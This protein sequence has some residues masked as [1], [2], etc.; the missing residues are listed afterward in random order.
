MRVVGIRENKGKEG[1]HGFSQCV[2]EPFTDFKRTVE[3]TESENKHRCKPNRQ[4][5]LIDAGLC[6]NEQLLLFILYVCV[7]RVCVHLSH[8]AKGPIPIP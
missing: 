2:F 5:V 1:C 8:V 3:E 6:H 7:S 4:T